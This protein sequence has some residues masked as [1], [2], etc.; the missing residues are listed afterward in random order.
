MTKTKIL[1]IKQKLKTLQLN[2]PFKF[3]QIRIKKLP[4]FLCPFNRTEKFNRIKM[5][6]Q[7][8]EKI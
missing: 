5:I 2:F 6:F 1:K 8:K 4:E 7:N 3:K